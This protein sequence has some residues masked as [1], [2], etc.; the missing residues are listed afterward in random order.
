MKNI[1]I[2][3]SGGIAAY[4]AAN[5]VSGLRKRG[6]DVKVVMTEN[7]AK[8]ITPL[9]FESLSKHDVAVDM[10]ERNFNVNVEHIALADWA[11]IILVAPATY[12]IVGK[13]AG[14]I[15]D[16]M[17]STVISA[18]NKT[19]YFALAMNVRMYENP[20]LAENIK[21]LKK[22]GYKFIE[23]DEGLLACN[24]N[25]KG[26]LKNEQEIIK[27]ISKELE[28]TE[29]ISTD[30][31]LA[32]KKVL[33]T[34]GRTE[35]PLDPIRYF[36]N[37]STGK[38]GYSL[39][40]EAEK[41]GA[42]VTIV[43]GPTNI[44]KPDRVNIVEVRTAE[45][46]YGEVMK[47]EAEQDIIIAAA[48]VADYRPEYTADKK[49]KKGDMLTVNFIRNKD[50]LLELGKIKKDK[51]LVGFA[52]ESENLIENAKEKLQKKNLDMI[53]VNSVDNFGTD[54]NT[55]T[56]LGKDFETDFEKM[57]KKKVSKEIWKT[58]EEKFL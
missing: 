4:K 24:V 36:S 23:A 7:A 52:A 11:D 20:I 22:Y 43:S 6:Y 3:V 49:I 38:M 5:I 25:A 19:V 48:A 27:I 16:D 33:I 30:K 17:L 26:R 40:E 13:V 28:E 37:R 53:V 46:M 14:G 42:D 47:Y 15:A 44:D 31:P 50:I 39:G 45:E 41:L 56:L 18:F 55:I 8:I 51:I 21:K 34:A 10:W 32:G 58:I 57:E 9:A 12:N 54:D 2:G 35:E 1:L 29:K